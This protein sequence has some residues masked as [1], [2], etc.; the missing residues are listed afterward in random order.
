ME[1]FAPTLKTGNAFDILNT[2]FESATTYFINWETI[3]KKDNTAIRDSE[4]KNLFERISE[5]HNRNLNFIVII[6]EEHQNNTSKADDIISSINAKY[7]I[8]V[9]ATPN[10][11]VVGEFYEISEI[12]VI[13]EGL[14]TRFMYINDRLDT[15]HVE[16]TLHET[17]ILLEKADEEIGRAHV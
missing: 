6:D 12:D 14:I 15:T 2:G 9:S 8:R 16:N 7:E 4:R 13:N 17:D 1:R 5:A 10:K 11:R 3:T